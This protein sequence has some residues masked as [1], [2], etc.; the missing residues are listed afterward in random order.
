[1]RQDLQHIK[2]HVYEDGMIDDNEIAMLRGIVE[3]SALAEEET[4]LL[5]DLN[6]VVGETGVN[7]E[8]VQLMM[9]A[10]SAFILKDGGTVTD[11]DAAWL[12]KHL[13]KDGKI[14]GNEMKI[15]KKIAAEATSTSA[16]F[17]TLLN[18]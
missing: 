7:E 4:L 2:M 13:L 14:D 12:K 8:F 10:V 3:K 18:T 11:D 1:M 16:D 5:L 9:D 17:D 6:N 15:V